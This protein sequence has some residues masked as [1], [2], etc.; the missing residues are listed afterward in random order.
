MNAHGLERKLTDATPLKEVLDDRQA[1]HRHAQTAPE[2]FEH[3]RTHVRQD[4]NGQDPAGAKA[5]RV[6][7]RDEVGIED[8]LHAGRGELSGVCDCWKR[9]R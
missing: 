7:R 4:V 2:S 1:R 5:L 6:R 9:D 8:V 3:H